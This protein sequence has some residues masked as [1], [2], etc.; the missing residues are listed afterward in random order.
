MGVRMGT[1]GTERKVIL[2]VVRAFLI[3][4]GRVAFE[5]EH[6]RI[7]LW[8]MANRDRARRAAAKY[9]TRPGMPFEVAVSLSARRTSFGWRTCSRNGKAIRIGVVASS[10]GLEEADDRHAGQCDEEPGQFSAT[11]SLSGRPVRS[12]TSR[13]T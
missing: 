9:T 13:G 7:G 11:S 4:D 6:Q 3:G 10:E 8:L 12:T 5:P 2:P 1:V